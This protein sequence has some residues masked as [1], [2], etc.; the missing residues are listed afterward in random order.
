MSSAMN[1]PLIL[2]MGRT[3]L[4]T[5]DGSGGRRKCP[6]RSLPETK[7]LVGAVAWSNLEVGQISP[8]VQAAGEC[9]R[10]SSSRLLEKQLLTSGCRSLL[11][12]SA[13]MVRRDQMFTPIAW[14][15]SC[16]RPSRM[17]RKLNCLAKSGGGEST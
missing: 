9:E 10:I 2:A 8:G 12:M 1:R 14:D 5:K 16:S 11:P 7:S 4:L 17:D 15:C 13:V 6:G 3:P